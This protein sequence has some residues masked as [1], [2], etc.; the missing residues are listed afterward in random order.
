MHEV[1]IAR[2]IVAMVAAEADGRPV[3]RV[4]L[5]IGRLAGVDADAVRFCFDVVAQGTLLEGALLEVREPAGRARCRACG[6]SFHQPTLFT[7][8]RCGARD[9]ERVS[10]EEL[11]VVEFE[12][13]AD[14][15]AIGAAAI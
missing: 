8:C 15:E 14:A 7:A 11:N 3:K 1:G 12:V 5:E 4:V 13:S 6:E 9:V 10:G 2:S